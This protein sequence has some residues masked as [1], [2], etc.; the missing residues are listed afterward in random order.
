MEL[1]FISFL[2]GVLSAAAPCILP[3]LPVIVG[4]S[5]IS[6]GA[7]HPLVIASSLALSVFLFSLLLKGTTYLLGVPSSLWTIVSGSILILL[8]LVIIFPSLWAHFSGSLSQ[9]TGALLQKSN[10]ERGWK[11]DFLLG[12]AL[13]PAFNSCSPTYA[14]IVAVILPV[15]F[16]EGFAYLLAYSLGL[17]GAVLLFGL[18]SQLMTS[19]IKWLQS[20]TFQ[21]VV[22]CLVLLVGAGIIFG[23]DKEIQAWMID[24]S[25]YDPIK[26]IEDASSSNVL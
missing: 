12:A 7:R 9:K 18:L 6:R 4:G 24:N 13:G 16:L 5:A 15:S 10:E 2:A 1:L 22:G 25:I 14:L 17:G 21:I 19:Y 3:V 11:R 26:K 23:A 8:G 20:R